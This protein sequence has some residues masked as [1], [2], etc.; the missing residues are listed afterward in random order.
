MGKA[1]GRKVAAFVVG[2]VV[3]PQCCGVTVKLKGCP[4]LVDLF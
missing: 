4:F 2:V 3:S 1:A